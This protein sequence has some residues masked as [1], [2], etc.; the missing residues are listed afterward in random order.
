[1]PSKRKCAWRI[2]SSL[3][4][5]SH[6]L[7]SAS[8]CWNNGNRLLENVEFLDPASERAT[9]FA[10]AT[11]AQEEFA[12]GFLLILV[13]R[14]VLKWNPLIYRATRDHACK[15]LVGIVMDYIE[16]EDF[17]EASKTWLK[18]H[19]ERKALLEAY[20]TSSNDREK[21]ELWKRLELFAERDHLLPAPVADSINILRHEKIRRWESSNWW[22]GEPP[23]YA[24]KAR[25]V[26][27]GKLDRMKQDAL[28]V[29]LSTNGAVSRTPLSCD[30]DAAA[31]METAKRF[32][33]L[34]RRLL[35]SPD[36]GIEYS[37]V[38]NAFKALFSRD[39]GWLLDS[40]P[41]SR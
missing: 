6:F 16:P 31:A 13:S 26:A 32:G 4:L 1:M 35:Q 34:V 5:N 29:R 17:F 39:G 19:E 40:V 33:D 2:S 15:Q 9:C 8:E 18:E 25:K 28:Y 30:H 36:G 7:K 3:A 27:A 10:L 22:W 12:K 38:E 11:I 41:G 23:I 20:K 37:K 24:E 14:G 21:Q